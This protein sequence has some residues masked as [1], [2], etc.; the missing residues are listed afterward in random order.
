MTT[1]LLAL[2]IAASP[3]LNVNLTIS[4]KTVSW[5]YRNWA[6]R[7]I[8]DELN[9]IVATST[10]AHEAL[11]PLPP[12]SNPSPGPTR[13]LVSDLEALLQHTNTMGQDPIVCQ[14]RGHQMSIVFLQSIKEIRLKPPSITKW[15]TCD[16]DPYSLLHWPEGR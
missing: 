3:I 10:P 11:H 8:L 4:T 7:P 16:T 1:N 6:L 14:Q 12:P 13:A 2:T 5:N 15:L 9:R